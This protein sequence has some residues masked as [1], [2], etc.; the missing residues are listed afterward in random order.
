MRDPCPDIAD[1][2]ALRGPRAIRPAGRRTTVAGLQATAPAAGGRAARR[3][4]GSL[5]VLL[6]LSIGI[7]FTS[8]AAAGRFRSPKISE[9]SGMVQ[10]RKHPGVFWTHNDS[11]DR[12]RIFAV[13]AGGRLLSEVAIEGA[14]A[15]DWEDIATDDAGHL[16]LGDIG[17]NWSRRRDLTVYRVP[18]PDPDAGE[19]AVR[20]DRAFRIRYPEQTAFPDLSRLNF[21]AEALFWAPRTEGETGTLYLLT[22]HRSDTRTV[23]YRFESLD[24]GGEVALTRISSFDV[25]GADAKLGGMVTGA[26]ATPDGRWL[27]VLTYHA[28][29]I[30]ERPARGDDYLSRPLNRIDL[31]RSIALQCE[32]IAWDGDDLLFGNEQGAILRIPEARQWKGPFP[33]P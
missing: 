33:A 30:F 4:L 5:A 28:V 9:P 10:S 14:K 16:Y 24:A 6:L 1:T 15:I 32:S 7:A 26:D 25:G 31:V 21:D 20:V 17:N 2:P 29:F 11:G 8:L 3:R 12:P 19:T 18:E 27:A 23:L 13:D 22:K